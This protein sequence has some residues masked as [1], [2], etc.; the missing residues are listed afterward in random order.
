MVTTGAVQP[1]LFGVETVA[2][3]PPVATILLVAYRMQDT[4]VES[5]QSALAQTVPCEIIVSDDGSGDEALQRIAPI[6]RD[7][8]GPHRLSVRSTGSNIGLCAHLGQLAPLAHTGILVFL[9]GD[10]IAYPHRVERL[11]EH[12]RRNPQAM[13]VGA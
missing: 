8:R 10:D 2:D 9:A 3:A 7:Y 13:I 5:L 6:V 1:S 12:L 11:V 4:I